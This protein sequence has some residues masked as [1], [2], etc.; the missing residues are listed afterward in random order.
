[1]NTSNNDHFRSNSDK[2]TG[3]IPGQILYTPKG[4]FVVFQEFVE[5]KIRYLYENVSYMNSKSILEK[6][7][8]ITNPTRKLDNAVKEILIINKTYLFHKEFGKGTFIGFSK[9][10]N[11]YHL[12]VQFEI[13]AGTN[14]FTYPDDINKTLFFEKQTMIPRVTIVKDSKIDYHQSEITNRKNSESQQIRKACNNCEKYV[15]GEC[16]GKNAICHFYVMSCSISESEKANWP[17]HMRYRDQYGKK[18]Y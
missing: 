12:Y 8:H 2:F 9:T 4:E 1:M 13:K 10:S 11:H 18:R 14:W 7:L 16:W 6:H 15:L 5:D 3:I 17:D